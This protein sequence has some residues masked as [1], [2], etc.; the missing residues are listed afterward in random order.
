MHTYAGTCAGWCANP[1]F[2]ERASS[3]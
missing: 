1:H 2:G 3:A